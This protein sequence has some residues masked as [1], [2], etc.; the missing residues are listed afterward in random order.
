MKLHL[1]EEPNKVDAVIGNEREFI[2]DDPIG[3]SQSGL[4]L[5][6]R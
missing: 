1:P 2:F 5:K 6:P 4:P 3:Q